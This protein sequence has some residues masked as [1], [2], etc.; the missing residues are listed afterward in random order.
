MCNCNNNGVIS[1]TAAN[2][3]L[4]TGCTAIQDITS[5]E[6]TTE[7]LIT[8]VLCNGD[9]RE[10]SVPIPEAD[11]VGPE[12]P[13]GPQGPQGVQGPAGPAGATGTPG[14][15]GPAGSPGPTGPAGPPGA[16]GPQGPAGAD[17]AQGEQGLQGPQGS[18]GQQGV[19]GASVQDV[20]VTQDPDNPSIVNIEFSI[21]NPLTSQTVVITR[22]FNIPEAGES[23]RTAKMFLKQN[24]AVIIVNP[25]EDVLIGSLTIPANT[26]FENNDRLE[27]TLLYA[28]DVTNI[29]LDQNI[30]FDRLSIK[31]NNNSFNITPTTDVMGSEKRIR[32][33]TTLE[34]LTVNS[35]SIYG[36]VVSTITAANLTVSSNLEGDAIS[37]GYARTTLFDIIPVGFA[38][39]FT[40]DIT[41][42]IRGR[43][44]P[45]AGTD[46]GTNL[47]TYRY[48]NRAKLVPN[49][50]L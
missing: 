24:N 21:F 36:E 23:Q 19:Q 8:I 9:I 20:I 48:Y 26:L 44:A 6:T 47:T 28:T 3:G 22:A 15:V 14:A 16:T 34:R 29:L 1:G 37:F 39:N 25:S 10:F 35:L 17:G 38:V 18:I 45:T 4:P 43:V 32:F 33:N 30:L 40:E 12:G 5:V 13:I 7:V 2:G 46:F 31:I 50:I 41:V 27:M 11:N 49:G 42:E